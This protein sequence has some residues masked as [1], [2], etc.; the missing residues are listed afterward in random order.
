V[1]VCVATDGVHVVCFLWSGDVMCTAM[2]PGCGIALYSRRAVLVEQ[3]RVYCIPC[4]GW[5][6]IEL[7]QREDACVNGLLLADV[8]WRGW[9]PNT[10]HG[11]SF[12]RFYL[13]RT[14]LLAKWF[15]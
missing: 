15:A 11:E 13:P 5:R 7:G 6:P 12:S 3:G 8:A 9:R 10:V 1:C 14:I 4:R 2:K